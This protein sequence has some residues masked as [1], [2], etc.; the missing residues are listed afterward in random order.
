MIFEVIVLA[1]A[2]TVRPTSLAALYAILSHSAPRRLMLAFVVVG[3][4]FTIGFGVLVVGAFHGIHLNTETSQRRAIVDIA[5]GV[6]LVLFGILVLTGRAKVRARREAPAPGQG[7]AARFE[8]RLTPLTAALAGP[9]THL[10]G[11]FYLVALNLIVAH[12]VLAAEEL[13]AVITYNA[14]WFVL[15]LVALVACIVRPAAAREIL[16]RVREWATGHSSQILVATGFLIGGA[17]VVRGV[18]GLQS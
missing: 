11:L 14:I 16:V 9:L 7:W 2:S 12:H 18:V 4:C 3:L 13:G 1:L 5:C 10:P 6:I 15:P 17:L 8:E